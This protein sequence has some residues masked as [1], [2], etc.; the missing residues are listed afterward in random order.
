MSL[1]EDYLL[2]P[3]QRLY[4]GYL[5]SAFCIAI[6]YYVTKLNKAS[7]NEIKAYWF[8]PSALLDYGYFIV[9]GLVKL[10]IILPLLWSAKTVALYVNLVL[11][12]LAAPLHLNASNLTIALCYTTALFVVS[13][14]SRYWLHR[15]FHT[16]P[17]LWQFH[18][19]HHSA[20]VLNP[21]TFYRVHPFENFLFGLRYSLSAGI[22]TG[23]FLWLFGTGMNIYMIGGA[24]IFIWLFSM[25]GGNLRHSHI[26][27]RYPKVL[28]KWFMSPAQHQLHHTYDYASFNYGGY[29]GIFDRLFGTLQTSENI[30]KPYQFGFP[31]KMARYYRS[32][33]HLF[34]QPF[35]DCWQ[36]WR[37]DYAQKKDN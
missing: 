20:E 26:Y 36:L 5:L 9:V 19:V 23:V 29:L 28:E 13:E 4:W 7:L 15:W 33:W 37:K 31:E 32:V 2:N 6:L 30:S 8:H 16:I 25:I 17:W 1:M 18:K 34:K 14:F 27:L 24:N 21:V 3:Q 12:K 22:V 11:L 10:H 35:S